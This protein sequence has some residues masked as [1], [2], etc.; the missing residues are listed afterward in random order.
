MK[1]LL[2]GASSFSGLWFA[3]ALADRAVEVT[4]P[5]RGDLE[6][7]SGIRRTRVRELAKVA[8]VV[9]RVEFGS[10]EFF[11]VLDRTEFDI[12]CHHAARG[13]DYRSPD[14]DVNLA[15]SENT[16]GFK[17]LSERLR[18]HACSA[19]ILTGSVFESDEGAGTEPR[20]AFSPYGLSKALTGSVIRY[21]CEMAGM[22]LGKFVIPN[23][24]GP[25]EEPRFCAYFVKAWASGET[26]EVRTPLY[27]RDNI[28]ISLLARA[29]ADFA[30]EVAGSKRWAR[31][32]PTQ[33][34]G[35]Q[36]AFAERFA[37]EMSL[38]VAKPCPVKLGVQTDFSEPMVRINTDLVDATRLGWNEAAS[39]DDI[40]AYYS[41]Q[42]PLR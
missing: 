26:P 2:T 1:A 12:F 16:C 14:F 23:P 21:W 3:R 41:Q 15:L 39:W 33:Y 42:L 17:A 29:Y 5:L 37:R 11:E 4:A 18:A 38:R 32:A 34:V 28:H 36:G 10:A 22:P 25:L 35:S 6:G 13:A 9:P 27:V 8:K 24:F 31:R 7:Y 20:R 19:V 30:M 40:A